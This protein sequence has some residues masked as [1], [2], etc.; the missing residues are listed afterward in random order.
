VILELIAQ[1]AAR[2][3]RERRRPPRHARPKGWTGPTMRAPSPPVADLA[4][5]QRAMLA[6]LLDEAAPPLSPL[7]RASMRRRFST[8]WGER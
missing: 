2:P 5:Y 1:E 7:N 8:M 4:P 3:P 6:G